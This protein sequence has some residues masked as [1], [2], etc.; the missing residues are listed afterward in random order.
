MSASIAVENTTKFQ[1]QIDET[2]K[3]GG[4]VSIPAGVHPCGSLYLRSNVE[5]H[6]EQGAVLQAAIDEP[7]LFRAVSSFSLPLFSKTLWRS[8]SFHEK[9]SF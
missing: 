7:E 8:S 6:L 5:L 4:R 2:A 3:V 9:S 1:V